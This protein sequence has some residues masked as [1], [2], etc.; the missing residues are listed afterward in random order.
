MGL[1]APGPEAGPALAQTSPQDSGTHEILAADS[2]R[3]A[4]VVWGIISYTRWPEEPDVLELCLVGS[5]RYGQGL[6]TA[7]PQMAGRPLR[8]HT[9]AK[10]DAA[11][12]R[13]CHA[14]Y[15]G[16]ISAAELEQLR[17]VKQPLLTIREQDPLCRSGS[18]FCLKVGA[19]RVSF[20]LNL[21]AVARSGLRVDPKVLL[22]GHRADRP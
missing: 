16:E 17:T 22:L 20:D 4:R 11:S 15:I 1:L 19:T 5:M 12:M 7:L 3:L 10:V 18:M 14:A 8:L 21:D 2:A 9:L 13:S 6:M